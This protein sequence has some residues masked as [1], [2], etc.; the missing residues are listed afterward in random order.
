MLS[1]FPMRAVAMF[2]VVL[3]GCAGGG[4]GSGNSSGGTC[5]DWTVSL[6]E[7][8]SGACHSVSACDAEGNEN[9][10]LDQAPCR[11]FCES[12]PEA[13]CISLAGCHRA[14]LVVVERNPA[15]G[16]FL[17]CWNTAQPGPALAAAC[18]SLDA[19]SCSRSDRCAAWYR[20]DLGAMQFDHCTDELAYQMASHVDRG[21]GSRA[22]SMPA[23]P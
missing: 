2:V 14:V 5:P 6:R 22:P 4:N 8:V 7:S 3:T 16:R 11:G 17:G 9:P 12:L 15:T 1:I 19:E 20:G 10:E 23:G 13:D 21:A 18:A